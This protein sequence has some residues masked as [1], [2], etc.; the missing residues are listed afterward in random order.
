MSA[1]RQA[2][3]PESLTPD[4]GKIYWHDPFFEGLQLDLRQFK[5]VLEYKKEHELSKESLKI[6]VIIKNKSTK[7][8]DHDI[9]RFFK[10]YNLIEYKSEKDYFSVWDY[11][12]VLAYA[13][14]YASQNKIPL[15]QITMTI[16]LTMY[17]KSLQKHLASEW[18]Q[19]IVNKGNGIYHVL[20]EKI[21]VQ[22]VQ[23]KKLA[24]DGA[25]FLHSLRSNL[26]IEDAKTIKGM[27]EQLNIFDNKNIYVVRMLQANNR[28]FKEVVGVDAFADIVKELA[29]E[30]PTFEDAIFSRFKINDLILK[31]TLEIL[32]EAIAMGLS[33]EQISQLTKLSIEE[34]EE[35]I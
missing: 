10:R 26:T 19:K 29:D 17:P 11:W 31:K 32:K 35:L 28:T 30:D 21:P 6:D 12:K 22:I 33:M 27:C 7:P 25:L 24:K 23:T 20:G 13:K 4:Q 16:V 3:S 2:Q 34:I 18:Q 1:D 15:K 9:A 5:D 14:L 8:L